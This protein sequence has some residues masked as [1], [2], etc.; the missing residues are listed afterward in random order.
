MSHNH[1]SQVTK[2]KASAKN[3]DQES[4][5]WTQNW[6]ALMSLAVATIG[7]VASIWA[8]Q[9]TQ[10]FD[11]AVIA[12]EATELADLADNVRGMADF[13]AGL[14][15][16]ARK[17]ESPDGQLGPEFE[18]FLS[19]LD[20][21]PLSVSLEELQVLAHTHDD[22]AGHLAQ[23]VKWRDLAQH[24]VDELQKM[25]KTIDPKL[26]DEN[27]KALAGVEKIYLSTLDRQFASVIST[28]QRA[29]SDLR[30]LAL[31]DPS[32]SEHVI[33]PASSTTAHPVGLH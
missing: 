18:P 8:V 29:A 6:I 2:S 33:E 26:G 3:K 25:R 31:P 19:A 5:W 1:S 28:C 21:P 13:R 32:V 30:R 15:D 11:S 7:L 10:R 24:E 27:R 22:T 23:C 14:I 4:G 17:H 16:I 12:A 9:R 20:L